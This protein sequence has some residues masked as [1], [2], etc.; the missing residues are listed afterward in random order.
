MCCYFHTR[1][2]CVQMRKRGFLW[3]T[4]DRNASR[5]PP[6]ADSCQF[7]RRADQVLF[8][9]S[10]PSYCTGS[11]HFGPCRNDHPDMGRPRVITGEDDKGHVIGTDYFEEHDRQTNRAAFRCRDHN[12]VVGSERLINLGAERFQL[13]DKTLIHFTDKNKRASAFNK[14]QITKKGNIHSGTTSRD[15]HAGHSGNLLVNGV[16]QSLHRNFFGPFPFRSLSISSSLL[17]KSTLDA[18]PVVHMVYHHLLCLPHMLYR[19]CSSGISTQDLRDPVR[20][21]REWGLDATPCEIYPT[22][23]SIFRQGEG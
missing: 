20:S 21:C 10:P 3:K 12:N 4:S 15:P 23:I 17:S 19:C 1:S 7:F 2:V 9:V 5:Y 18:P 11:D 22:L 6:D 8:G 13:Q 16:E 14:K